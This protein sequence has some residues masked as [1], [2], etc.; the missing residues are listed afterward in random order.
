M[1]NRRIEL[2]NHLATVFTDSNNPQF[3]NSLKAKVDESMPAIF[4]STINETPINFTSKYEIQHIIKTQVR[5]KGAPGA[6]KIT[7]AVLKKTASRLLG[8][9]RQYLQRLIQSQSHAR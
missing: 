4:T 7:I 6:D 9:P 2:A 8:N 3:N 5:A 1:P